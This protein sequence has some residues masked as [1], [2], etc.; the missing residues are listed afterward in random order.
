METYICLVTQTLNK[1]TGSQFHSFQL[2][3]A[4]YV[5]ASSELAFDTTA[6]FIAGDISGNE[7]S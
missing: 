4:N 2:T 7:P 6:V 3:P 1:V 5:P